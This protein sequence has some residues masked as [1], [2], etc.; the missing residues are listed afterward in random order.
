MITVCEI[1]A[2]P[3]AKIDVRPAQ[4]QGLAASHARRCQQ[5]ERGVPP[6]FCG[7]IQLT[8]DIGPHEAA[9]AYAAHGWK[10][11]PVDHP[12]LRLYRLHAAGFDLATLRQDLGGRDLACWCP[13]D[14]PCHA[15]VL[16]E[17]ANP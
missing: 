12:T 4:T 15:D 16:L 5:D 17:L 8:R 10:V 2:R 9:L 11:F 3:A 7:V 6:V 13:L 14:Q 1:D